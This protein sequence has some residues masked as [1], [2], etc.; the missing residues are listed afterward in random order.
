MAFPAM[1][2]HVAN[3]ILPGKPIATTSTT[4]SVSVELGTATSGYSLF[5][6]PAVVDVSGMEFGISVLIA[7][8][9]VVPPNTTIASGASTVELL[10]ADLGATGTAAGSTNYLT[11]ADDFSNT[12]TGGWTTGLMRTAGGT[13]T[14]DLDADDVIGIQSVANLTTVGG[15]GTA[16]IH[17]AYIFGKPGAIN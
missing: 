6:V 4:I 16:G 11:N 10:F 15:I 1:N 9:S 12:V 13:S 3:T 8:G 5:E 14:T 17:V 7:S 2:A